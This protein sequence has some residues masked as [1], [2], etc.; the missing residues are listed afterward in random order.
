MIHAFDPLSAALVFGGTIAATLLS[1]GWRDTRAAI[2]AVGH[3][4]APSFDSDSVRATLAMQV[5]EIGQDGLIRAEPHRVGDGEFDELSET[6]VRHRSI[7]A[8]YDEHERHRGQRISLAGAAD[9]ALSEAAELAPVLGLAGTLVSLG[10]LADGGATDSDY[11][12]AI[13]MAVMTTLYG[14][15]AAHFVFAPLAGA[16]ER[17]ARAE[18]RARQNLLDWLAAAI[19]RAASG[20][21]K[22]PQS[23]AAA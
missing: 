16:I 9:R 17:R 1:C 11:A 13:G 12:R 22:H 14:L 5:R 6:L 21:Q 8:L 4:F 10:W 20:K 3:L 2:Q 15:V 19:E 18:E 7:K 23:K